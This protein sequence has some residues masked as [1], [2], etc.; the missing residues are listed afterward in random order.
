MTEPEVDRPRRNVSVIGARRMATGARRAVIG[1]IEDN[2]IG[3]QRFFS[4]LRRVSPQLALVSTVCRARECV[5]ARDGT[6]TMCTSSRE[7][8]LRNNCGFRQSDAPPFTLSSE[9][10]D[11]Y[12]TGWVAAHTKEP[13]AP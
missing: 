12:C 7:D 13:D 11:S 9:V 5:I 3:Q 10:L 8:T 1:W 4:A 2:G 6:R